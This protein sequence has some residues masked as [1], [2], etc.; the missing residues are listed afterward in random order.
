FI[1]PATIRSFCTSR[2]LMASFDF[3]IVTGISKRADRLRNSQH[4]SRPVGYCAEADIGRDALSFH[5]MVKKCTSRSG[6]ARMCRITLRKKIGGASSSLI[7]TAAGKRFT[8]GEFATPSA[9]RFG[10]AQTSFG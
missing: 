9:S 2:I 5:P 8:P 4:I 10:Q 7:L 1:H 3:L 6:R